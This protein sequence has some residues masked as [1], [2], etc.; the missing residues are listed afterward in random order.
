MGRVS[1][2]P[3]AGP[4]Q[5]PPRAVPPR[6]SQGS[7]HRGSVSWPGGSQRKASPASPCPRGSISQTVRSRAAAAEPRAEGLLNE[8]SNK[9]AS[10]RNKDCKQCPRDQFRC[11]GEGMQD[12][13]L[14]RTF[15]WNCDVFETDALSKKTACIET[16]VRV[17]EHTGGE[18]LKPVLHRELVEQD[19][20]QNKIK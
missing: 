8:S 9:V 3:A 20:Q 14:C 18:N 17:S 4:S 12:L 11:A 19:W 5:P 2:P 6:L 13:R 1:P 7:T 16:S 10:S 15:E